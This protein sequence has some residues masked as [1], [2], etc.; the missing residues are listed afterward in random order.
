MAFGPDSMIKD[1]LAHEEA[2]AVIERFLPGAT[3]HPLLPE[4]MY[5]TLGE[6][7]SYPQAGISRQTYAAILDELSRISLGDV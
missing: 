6:V 1:V 4:V 2:R 7:A 3:Q 5:L